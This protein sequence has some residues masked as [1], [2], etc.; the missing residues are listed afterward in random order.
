MLHLKNIGILSTYNSATDSFNSLKNCSI[1]IEDNAFT[2]DDET[3]DVPTVFQIWIKKDID[4][5][6]NTNLIGTINILKK[7]KK[8]KSKIIFLS[9]SRVYPFK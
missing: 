4:R 6:I 1:D 2:I 7:V 9:S 8:D 3:H 5:V